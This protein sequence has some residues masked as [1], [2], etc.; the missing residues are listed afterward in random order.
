MYF[1]PNLSIE[2]EQY[3]AKW[4]NEQE[5]IRNRIIKQRILDHINEMYPQR[6]EGVITQDNIDRANQK[7]ITELFPDHKNYMVKCPFHDDSRASAS[8]KRGFLKCFACG[9]SSDV[10]GVYQQIHGISFAEAVKALQ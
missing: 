10:I 7:D 2:D 8:I 4:W 3:W 1:N 9:K 6:G 5:R